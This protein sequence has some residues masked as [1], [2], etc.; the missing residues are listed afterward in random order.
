MADVSDEQGGRGH[1]GFI[2]CFFDF[3]VVWALVGFVAIFAFFYCPYTHWVVDHTCRGHWGFVICFLDFIVVWALVSF[4][5]I[6]AFFYCP[7]TYHV[8]DH[9][10]LFLPWQLFHKFYFPKISTM[11]AK[12]VQFAICSAKFSYGLLMLLFKDA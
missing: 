11:S 5:V 8:V 3:I 7:C 12:R 1:W 6:F 9:T 10:S 4:I 2:I